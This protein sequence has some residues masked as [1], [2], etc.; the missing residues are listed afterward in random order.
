MRTRT[1]YVMAVGAISLAIF[2]AMLDISVVTV[3]LPTIEA[4]FA[5][6]TSAVQWV[7]LGYSLVLAALVMPAGRWLDR[8]GS[9]AALIAGVIGFTVASCLAALA[10][11]LTLLIGARMVQ[12]GCA[13]LIFAAVP[14]LAA[15]ISPPGARG[16]TIGTVG[17]IGPLGA[18]S[19]P[20][21]GGILLSTA[22]WRSI[23][24]I[25][26]PISLVILAL[27][28]RALPAEGHLRAPNQRELA[29]AG[30][31]GGSVL[32][33][34]LALTLTTDHGP[35]WLAVAV[36]AVPLLVV[37]LRLPGGQPLARIMSAR[38]TGPLLGALTLLTTAGT[39][40]QFLAP[41]I[42]QQIM[43]APPTIVGFTV[44]MFPLA[45]A[46][47]GPLAG[48]AADRWGNRPVALTG[49]AVL[50]AALALTIPFTADS[51]PLSIGIRMALAGI[52]NGLFVSPNQTAILNSAD[53]DLL[54]STSAASG[55][56]RSIAFAAGPALA[57][58]LWSAGGSGIDG[59]RLALTFAVLLGI[60]GGMAA[61]VRERQ[62]ATDREE[63]TS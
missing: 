49:A 5:A 52:G 41:Y 40:L 14:A 24:L 53:R 23:F 8:V 48:F 16:R 57:T 11:W 45:M 15:R 39:I 22:G 4:D 29:E 54:G 47:V 17:A 46:T 12:G 63:S 34:L 7:A 9:R 3:A 43:R 58:A 61:R 18:V 38:S 32:A 56:A 31:F 37:L 50:T 10:P 2:M 25:N 60:T 59:M 62:P 20:A 55:L 28:V 44:L 33:C 21:I 42:L 6:R 19:G 1:I 13:A 26:V 36:L 27:A 30:L 51:G 35:A